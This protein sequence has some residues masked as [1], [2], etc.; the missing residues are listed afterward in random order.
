MTMVNGDV[1]K[2]VAI[3]YVIRP[4]STGSFTISPAT[5]TADGHE[6]KSNSVSIKVDK[7][8]ANSGS[9]SGGGNSFTSPFNFPD[10]FAD[11]EPRTRF[12]DNVLRK[13]ESPQEKIKNN[14]IVRLETDKTSCYVGEPIVASY[15]LYTRLRSESNITK[16]PSFSGFSVI[17]L[18]QPDNLSS[19]IEKLNGREYNVYTI[20][21]VQ[22][23][24]LQ[25]GNLELEK[26]EV[27]N[28]VQFIKAEY[29][30]KQQDMFGD[31]FGDNTA[32]IPSEGI[33]VQ[34]VTL[35]SKP[36]SIL[37]KPL[38][39]P[40]PS[41]FKGAVGNFE[42]SASMPKYNF[43]TDD[44]GSLTVIINGTGNMQMVTAPDISWPN[45][46]EGFEPKTTDDIYK[47]TV[48]V[49][50]RKIIEYPFTIS[51]AGQYTL[52]PVNFSFFD[53]RSGVYKTIYTKPI[54]FTVTQGSG[55][56]KTIDT[57]AYKKNEPNMLT[58][59]FSNR[60]RVV[61]VVAVLIILGLIIWLKRDKK[62][63]E[64]ERALQE[65]ALKEA[66]PIEAIIE[67]QTNPLMDA[68]EALF[69]GDGN[70]F[71]AKLN[72]SFKHYLS[73]KFDIP[74]EYL[75]KKSINEKMDQRSIPLSTSL[76]VNS[77]MDEIEWQLFTPS[78]D[79]EKMQEMYERANMLVQ[80][81][82]NKLLIKPS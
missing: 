13:G 68:E 33:E 61:S 42:V 55:K 37:V 69:A 30:N 58:K 9:S 70:L 39:D 48:P 81:I 62:R 65:L 49:S 74:V 56:P 26:A 2:Y 22:L 46:I 15:K 20:R 41:T 50:G 53:P 21:K 24:P 45:E 59:F 25:S 28:N 14:I 44:A 3:T 6:L 16:N 32:N 75:N 72:N 77:L 35:Q 27:E 51:A 57:S 54:N 60:L 66:E 43:T 36:L 4:V 5:A 71:Y 8:Y 12:N 31:L 67:N 63:D 52:P 76:Q 73:H 17:D 11:A 79:A 19:H 29:L 34:K 18:Q 10:P 47:T 38:P 80:E 78:V 1:K 7:A 64:Q 82:N 40:K 23:Y